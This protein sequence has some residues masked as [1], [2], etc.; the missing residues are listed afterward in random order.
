MIVESSLGSWYFWC[1]KFLAALAMQSMSSQLIG[2]RISASLT[3]LRPGMTQAELWSLSAF[4]LL[5]SLAICSSCFHYRLRLDQA[6]AGSLCA[7]GEDTGTE[8]SPQTCPLLASSSLLLHL[9]SRESQIL[10]SALRSSEEAFAVFT[11]AC[12]HRSVS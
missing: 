4:S 5:T 12:H 3:C 11:H 7:S 10:P 2:L 9:E 6:S 8:S 1:I